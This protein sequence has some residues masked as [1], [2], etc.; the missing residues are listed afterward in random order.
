MRR[1]ELI[2]LLGARLRR[3]RMPRAHQ[4]DRARRRRRADGDR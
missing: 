2:A 4:P 3:G 1:R